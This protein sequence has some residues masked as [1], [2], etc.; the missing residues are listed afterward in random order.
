MP[1][2]VEICSGS[3]GL[4]LFPGYWH[5]PDVAAC[6][7][8]ARKLNL[9]VRLAVPLLLSFRVAAADSVAILEFSLQKIPNFN[10]Y[11]R[12]VLSIFVLI[13]FSFLKE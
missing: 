6:N 8:F 10:S 5:W 7:L 4:A 1:Q 3:A 12:S 13:Q 9:L 11:F 2:L